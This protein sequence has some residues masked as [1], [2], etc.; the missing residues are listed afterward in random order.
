M[1]DKE[2]AQARKAIAEEF[3]QRRLVKAVK[4]K[5]PDAYLHFS[6]CLKDTR[7]A[8]GVYT[9]H[10]DLIGSGM[11]SVVAWRAAARQLRV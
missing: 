11:H 7:F 8:Y 5:R 6:Y 10:C 9:N 1:T 2:I 3:E 4:K